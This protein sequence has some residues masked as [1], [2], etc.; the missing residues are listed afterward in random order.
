MLA[1]PGLIEMKLL[2]EFLLIEKRKDRHPPAEKWF[3]GLVNDCRGRKTSSHSFLVE[4]S[5]HDLL[6]VV[7]RI[8]PLGGL[9]SCLH[10]RQKQRHQHTRR[11]RR[12]AYQTVGTGKRPQGKRAGRAHENAVGTLPPLSLNYG[13]P[14]R[15]VRHDRRG[16]GQLR[17]LEADSL[18]FQRSLRHR[19]RKFVGS[20]QRADQRGRVNIA[21]ERRGIAVEGLCHGRHIGKAAVVP[22]A[23]KEGLHQLRRERDQKFVIRQTPR[24]C[25]GD[26]LLGRALQT[27]QRLAPV[28]DLLDHDRKTALRR[29]RC[30]TDGSQK[31][32]VGLGKRG[33]IADAHLDGN[34]RHRQDAARKGED[35]PIVTDGAKEIPV[36]VDTGYR[37]HLFERLTGT[38]SGCWID[39]PRLLDRRRERSR[40]VKLPCV[41]HHDISRNFG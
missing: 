19:G 2:I 13:N 3:A 8:G 11:G 16:C 20:A 7:A 24:G 30:V 34:I 28:L 32:R 33:A 39:E 29:S 35:P 6:A 37:S 17:Q 41:C 21:D 4:H 10:G 18:L 36:N 15:H 25:D 38:G 40:K 22:F 31:R 23:G 26:R 9:A 5:E 12:T 14:R 27:K 1:I